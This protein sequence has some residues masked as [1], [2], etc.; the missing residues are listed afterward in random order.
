M[1]C[2]NGAKT[3]L[4]LSES[5]RKKARC[6]DGTGILTRFPFAAVELRSSLGSTNPQLIIIAEETL[7]YTTEEILTLLNYY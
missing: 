2:L 4:N 7:P 5:V 6:F 1:F 3:P